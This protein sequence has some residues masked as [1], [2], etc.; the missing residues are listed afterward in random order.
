MCLL[1]L[2]GGE[3]KIEALV[4]PRTS[5]DESRR[6]PIPPNLVAWAT[7]V[8]IS[9]SRSGRIADEHHREIGR[10]NAERWLAHPKLTQLQRPRGTCQGSRGPPATL[11]YSTLLAVQ[12]M[13]STSTE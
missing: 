6:L 13:G 11:P 4:W 3:G 12:P 9:R 2:S 10:L 5:A 1:R 7:R 8:S